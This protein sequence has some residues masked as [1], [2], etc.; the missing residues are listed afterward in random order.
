MN[1]AVEF[2][3]GRRQFLKTL[4]DI[5]DIQDTRGIDLFIAM[6]HIARLT[7]VI[8]SQ[9]SQD[10]DISGPRFRLLLR[11]YIMGE[12][13]VVDGLTPTEISKWQRVTKNTISSLLRGL[14]EQG[15]VERRLDED[16]LRVFRIRL[17]SAGRELVRESAPRHIE[18]L[19]RMFAALSDDE[20]TQLT[21]LMHKLAITLRDHILPNGECER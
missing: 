16:D 20:V 9:M 19:N 8:D 13:G 1:N 11:L 5:F 7:E 4:E 17:T 15:L 2:E 12:S 10:H 18:G 21:T 3:Q 14:E 6:N